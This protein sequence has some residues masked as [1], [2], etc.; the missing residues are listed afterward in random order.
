MQDDKTSNI[1][2]NSDAY[3]K[4]EADD[5]TVIKLSREKLLAKA[6]TLPKSPGCYLMQGKLGEILYVGKAK[7][8]KSRV[9]SYFNNSEK[10]PKTKI[11]VSHIKNFEFILTNSDAESYVLENNLIKEHK[12]KY[13]IRL[14]DDKS[15]P[16]LGVDWSNDF[17][18]LLYLRRPKKRKNLELFGPFPQGYNVSH[19]LRILT[20]SFALRDCSN[21]EFKNRTTPCILYQ[22][23]QCTAPCV[24]KI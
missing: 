4:S 2:L 20:K 18:R 17:P 15:Y 23:N 6:N 14:K 19:I 16:Y 3:D 22:M 7:N 1:L 9:T 21:H 8:L 5:K 12:P 11:L 24:N 13:N 10:N